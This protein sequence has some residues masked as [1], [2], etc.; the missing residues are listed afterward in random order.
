MAWLQLSTGYNVVVH[1]FVWIADR[2]SGGNGMGS[3]VDF[4][5]DEE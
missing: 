1:K 4:K 3:G 5:A 2:E